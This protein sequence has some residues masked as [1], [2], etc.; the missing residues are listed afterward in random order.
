M[1]RFTPE[2]EA[3]FVT[4]R[5]RLGHRS[6]LPLLLLVPAVIL[7]AAFASLFF[8]FFLTMAVVLGTGVSLRLWWLRRK[9]RRAADTHTI[10]ADYVIIDKRITRIDTDAT[11]PN[12]GK[13]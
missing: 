12:D 5:R 13:P 11:R 9:L 2:H 4:M 10:D 6:L 8:A 7:I 1:R 3:L